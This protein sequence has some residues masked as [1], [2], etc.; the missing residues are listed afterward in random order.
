MLRCAI[1][2]KIRVEQPGGPVTLCNSRLVE[3]DMRRQEGCGWEPGSVDS[4]EFAAGLRD[5]SGL[6][7]RGDVGPL[8]PLRG[9]LPVPGRIF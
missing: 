9:H 2:D 8:R 1:T 3:L 7:A 4:V 5:H 6:I